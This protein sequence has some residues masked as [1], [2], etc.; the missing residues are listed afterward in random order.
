MG[1]FCPKKNTMLR[2]LIASLLLLLFCLP[3]ASQNAD[4]TAI[5]SSYDYLADKY[6]QYKFTDSIKARNYINIF[7]RKAKKNKDTLEVANS[8]FFWSEIKNNKNIY[9][10]HLDS[11]IA[12]TAINPN[13]KFPAVLYLEKGFRCLFYDLDN[14]SLKS[15]I[16]AIEYST[17]FK[18][19]SIKYNAK[20]H[21]G[22]L[23]LKYGNVKDAKNIYMEVYEY[24]ENNIKSVNKNN[25][26]SVV[27]EIS[28]LYMQEQKYDS[29]YFY[30][31]KVISFSKSIKDS[32]MLSY[33][34]YNR[35]KIK[36][37]LNN[38][39]EAITAFNLAIPQIIQD[40]NF[41]ILSNL[42]NLLAKSHLKL[43]KEI[44]SLKYYLKIDSLYQTR[45]LPLNSGRESY[46]FLVDYYR[47]ANNQEK[48]LEY[49]EKLIAVDSILYSNN[50]D[51]TETFKSEYDIPKLKAEKELIINELK[52]NLSKSKKY[53]IYIS[54]TTLIII[55]LL[56]SQIKKRKV[57]KEKF[58]KAIKRRTPT[59]IKVEPKIKET[60]N[61]PEEV[62]KNVLI[63]LS[64]FE[65]N[66]DFINVALSLKHLSAQLET[67]PNYLSKIINYY[68]NKSYSS[69]IRDLRIDYAIALLNKDKIIR[70]Y[71]IKAIAKEVGF[72]TSESF[73]NAFHK[74]LGV[75]P[76]YYIKKLNSK[77]TD[78]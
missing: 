37:K 46:K 9:L 74:K 63:G 19:D 61:I 51:L 72:N 77:E 47:K 29:A 1:Y 39:N 40:E 52:G 27:L 20:K 8:Y 4:N 31:K 13:K 6:Y 70:K 32:V 30:N 69:Y 42:Y 35:G 54:I 43:H 21:L 38:Y 44:I 33:A 12:K 23:K 76:S 73:A 7:T 26:F 75:K 45:K 78:C 14:E 17:K 36:F 49:I 5:D 10:N 58:N 25:Y 60:L 64:E 11:M 66:N 50:K 65:K 24:Y 15:Y 62:T 57:L 71:T 41:I 16:S 3:I 67:N 22:Y 56:Y 59:R 53:L 34:L 48:H 68:H 55:I 18:N 2:K 28:H